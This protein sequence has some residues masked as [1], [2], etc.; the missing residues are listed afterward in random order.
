M[1]KVQLKKNLRGKTPK[2]PSW[3][4]FFFTKRLILPFGGNRIT[5]NC[6]TIFSLLCP[7][8]HG[9]PYMNY[10]Q[11]VWRILLHWRRHTI[12]PKLLLFDSSWNFPIL[13][14]KIFPFRQWWNFFFH[15]FTCKTLISS[16]DFFAINL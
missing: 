13:K 16:R 7:L 2:V 6:G 8:W 11:Y 3:E 15:I 5:L 9:K 12:L 10:R 4:D 1:E 14:K